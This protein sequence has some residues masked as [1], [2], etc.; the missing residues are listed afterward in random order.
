[1]GWV[2]G[3]MLLLPTGL[4][5]PR[6]GSQGSWNSP[7]LLP[8][9]PP[10]LQGQ[11]LPL[12]PRSQVPCLDSLPSP[13]PSSPSLL[14]PPPAVQL[15]T[16]QSGNRGA[17]SS[18]Y[19]TW[20]SRGQEPHGASVSSPGHRGSEGDSTALPLQ[21]DFHSHHLAA[22]AVSRP[23]SCLSIIKHIHPRHRLVHRPCS[24][25]ICCPVGQGNRQSQDRVLR[26]AMLAV[27]GAGSR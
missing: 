3:E 5:L 16:A 4:S 7:A 17:A 2:L 18:L 23:T 25:G 24:Q 11:A 27:K 21:P 15:S 20:D 13:E 8:S 26:T 1:M 22:S 12:H 6:E 10:G 14:A 9:Q 19:Q